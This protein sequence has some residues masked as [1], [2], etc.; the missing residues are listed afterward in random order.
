MRKKILLVAILAIVALLVAAVVFVGRYTDKF[1]D[2]YVRSL[3]E[4]T[5]P[6]G[7]RIEYQKIRVN[8]F[9]GDIIIKEVR[10]FPDSLTSKDSLRMEIKV[11]D[12]ELTNFSIKEFLFNKTLSVYE[13]LIE[14]PDVKLMLP[15][16][17]MEAI[18]EV[19][20]PKP[21]KKVSQLLTHINLERIVF[22]MGSFQ[23]IRG[24][25]VLAKS[26]DINLLAESITLVKNSKEEPI[27]YTY[28]D[29][30]LDLSDIELYSETGLY[31]MSLD[32]FY[33]TKNDSTLLL[34]GFKMIPKYDKKE[35][36]T[37]LEFVNDRFDVNIGEIKVESVGIEQ[38][39]AGGPL[40][41]SSIV[42]DS[43]T[44]DIYR[45]HNVPF[46]FDRFPAFYNESFMK[47]TLPLYIDS[48]IITNS[49][50]IYGEL[51]AGHP[52]AGSITLDDFG[53]QI[54]E[55]TNQVDEDTIENF[56]HLNVQAKVMGEGPLNVELI[57]PLEGD[58]H[59][60]TCS[61]SVGAMPLVPLNDMLEPAINMK[62][63]GGRVNRMTFFFEANDFASKGWMEF[64]YQDIDVV[65]LKKESEKQWGFISSLANSI[66]LSNNPLPGKD[67]KIVEIGYE[68]NKNKGII[69]Y[70][71]KT[72]Q[73]GMVRTI[74]P[75]NKFQINRQQ[76]KENRRNKKEAKK[77]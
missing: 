37:K 50:I 26:N 5:K 58:L 36:S 75:T 52:K 40:E 74:I 62:F 27:G 25:I 44:A 56:M 10:L 18:E 43:L 3:L 49:K 57:L 45:D 8:L 63:N 34:E 7:H 39:L 4:S 30:N 77:N 35:F 54:Y 61:G 29:I 51:I 23:L 65:L 67:L 11:A 53:V 55:L 42:I 48:V 47:L 69:N 59:Q 12:V 64:L 76:A 24:D 66:A 16:S 22:S 9:S 60:F 41:I 15:D 20:E 46:N 21:P 32:G 2:P 13:I 68:R 14:N 71:W 33:F 28:G 72:I 70:V 31:D 17:T 6:M 73:S 38:F 19:R 1:I